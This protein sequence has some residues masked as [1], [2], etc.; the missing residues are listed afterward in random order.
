MFSNL[1]FALGVWLY[2]TFTSGVR[3]FSRVVPVSAYLDSGGIF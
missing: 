3:E 1:A 2:L